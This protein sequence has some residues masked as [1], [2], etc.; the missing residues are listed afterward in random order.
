MNGDDILSGSGVNLS[1]FINSIEADGEPPS[2]IS[3]ALKAMWLVQADRWHEAHDLCQELESSDNAWVHAYLHRLEGDFSNA[4]YWYSIAGK[5]QPPEER[6][7]QEE[8]L[9]MVE[10]MLGECPPAS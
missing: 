1:D 3:D 7:L 9:A 8:W 5:P 4:G 2:G 10:V 6:S